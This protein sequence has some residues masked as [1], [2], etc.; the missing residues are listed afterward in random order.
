[1]KTELKTKHTRDFFE[2]SLNKLRQDKETWVA[3]RI[4]NP[5]FYPDRFG[6]ALRRF[7]KLEFE[8]RFKRWI[9]IF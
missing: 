3:L 8:A 5:T 2:Q 7:N 6:T 4:Y 1:M 9:R